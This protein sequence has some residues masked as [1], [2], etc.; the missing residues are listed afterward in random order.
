MAPK[1]NPRMVFAPFGESCDHPQNASLNAK[2][3]LGCAASPGSVSKWVL[4]R[5]AGRLSPPESFPPSSPPGTAGQQCL[6]FKLAVT[7]QDSHCSSTESTFCSQMVT[8]PF[9]KVSMYLPHSSAADQVGTG[10]S[11]DSQG[12]FCSPNNLIVQCKS[13]SWNSWMAF[14]RH[15]CS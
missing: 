8:S 3:T 7:T 14:S 12:W 9:W 6:A 2:D 15:N 11:E 5:I 13:S 4:I 10:E 1:H